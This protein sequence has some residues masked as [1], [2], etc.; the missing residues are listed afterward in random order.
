MEHAGTFR[1]AA[2]AAACLWVASPAALEDVVTD[3]NTVAGDA[4]VQAKIG[5][6][7]ANRIMAIV[8]T[9]VHEA[10][11]AAQLQH[12]ADPAATEAVC[13]TAWPGVRTCRLAP[14]TS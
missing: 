4:I 1:A 12:A 7:P 9:A 11:A 2:L 5:T 14:R 10:V 6:P 13:R 8:Q 3:W